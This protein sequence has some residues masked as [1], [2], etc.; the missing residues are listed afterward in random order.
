[1]G[2][3]IYK[4]I[5]FLFAVYGLTAI[6]IEVVEVFKARRGSRPKLTVILRVINQEEVIEGILR[7]IL[8]L[9]WQV[10]EME[11]IVIDGGSVDDTLPI[12]TRLKSQG[13]FHLVSEYDKG[14]LLDLIEQ[15]SGQLVCY[16]DLEK[17]LELI[18]DSEK[19]GRILREIA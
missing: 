3:T 7:K 13:Q 11:L 5:I 4:I 10:S 6:I 14:F 1:M 19:L 12:L 2:E 16:L 17:D 18:N 15:S 9:S 8:K